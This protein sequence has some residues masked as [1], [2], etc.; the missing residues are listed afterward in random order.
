VNTAET[1]LC[2]KQITRWLPSRPNRVLGFVL[3]L[4][5]Y[6]YHLRLGGLIG[7]RF[8]L[9][10]DRGRRSG[11]TRRIPLEV[12]HYDSYSR[13][14][15]VLSERRVRAGERNATVALCFHL[16][17]SAV[18]E[19]AARMDGLAALQ[20]AVR[21]APEERRYP[22]SVGKLVEEALADRSFGND[23]HGSARAGWVPAA[24]SKG[25]GS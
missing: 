16:R 12:L 2:E 1:K 25:S 13:E 8:L 9:L 23:P 20:L 24:G 14:S 15:V 11:L 18:C 7:H 3:R 10:T 5:S 4:P 6:L 21:I 17:E 19:L 22:A